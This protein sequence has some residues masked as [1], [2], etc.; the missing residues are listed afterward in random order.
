MPSPFLKM[1]GISK[2]YPG[3]RALDGIS[4]SVSPGEVIGL[5]GENGAGKSTL[6]KILGGVVAPSAGS[7]ELDGNEVS[8]LTVGGSMVVASPSCIRNSICSRT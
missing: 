6:M 8:Q 2:E 3:I 7:I 4:L 1:T 5:V